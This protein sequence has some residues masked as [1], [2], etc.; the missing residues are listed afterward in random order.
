[1]EPRQPQPCR[2]ITVSDRSAAGTREDRSGPVLVELLAAAGYHVSAAIVPD[3]EASVQAAIGAALAAGA[4]LVVTTGGTGVGP[5]DRTPEGTRAAV[6]RELP[7]VAELLRA[8]GALASAHA[9]LGRG[10]AG[11]VDATAAHPGALVVN[12]PGSPAA[13]ADGIAVVLPLVPHVLDQLAGG[14]HP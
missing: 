2:V 9:A 6:D 10:I 5:R 3:G 13:A 4:R 1:M 7:G 8:R 12:L 11:V 14:D